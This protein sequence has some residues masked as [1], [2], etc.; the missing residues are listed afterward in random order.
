MRGTTQVPSVYILLRKEDKIAFLLRHN[1]D[2]M[3]GKYCVPTGHVEN[4]E[5]YTVAATREAKEET[6][7][8]IQPEDLKYIHTAAR[9]HEDKDHV[10]LDIYFEADKWHGDAHNAEPNKHSELVWFDANNLPYEKIIP[11]HAGVLKEIL[12]GKQFSEHG[13]AN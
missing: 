9:L 2:Y 10:R 8:T 13:W 5:K 7:V 1:T 6:G 12:V 11:S 4:L 3:N